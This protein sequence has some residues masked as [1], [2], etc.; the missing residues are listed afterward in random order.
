MPGKGGEESK[1]RGEA[2]AMPQV[3][4]EWLGVCLNL[5]MRDPPATGEA[6]A[7]SG[8]RLSKQ[9]RDGLEETGEREGG[10]VCWR[11]PVCALASID[12]HQVRGLTRIG[13]AESDATE[14]DAHEG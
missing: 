13:A 1:R 4:N 5:G 10:A 8:L 11:H 7:A 14:N 6:G 3:F 2:G 12:V 9:V